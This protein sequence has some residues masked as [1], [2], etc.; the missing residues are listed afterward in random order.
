MNKGAFVQRR[1]ALGGQALS[2]GLWELPPGKK[3]FP[4]HMHH[5]TEEAM[6]VISGAAKVRTTEG[7]TAIGP[8]DFVSFL[9]GVDAHQLIND[10]TEP[11]VYVGM[12]ASKGVDVV[13]YPDSNKVAAAIGSAPGGKRFVFK[14]SDEAGYFDGEKDAQ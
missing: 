9:P 11:L 5:I 4:F 6:F 7:E 13:D 2:C 8:G 14:K 12:S 1:K 3:S 10:G